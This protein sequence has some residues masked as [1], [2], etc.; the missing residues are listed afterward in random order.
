MSGY[1][2]SIIQQLL[3]ERPGDTTAE[4]EE[5][6]IQSPDGNNHQLRTAAVGLTHQVQ[7]VGLRPKRWT[8]GSDLKNFQFAGTL[9]HDLHNRRCQR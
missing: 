6:G 8:L 3:G 7:R 9:G 4:T 2:Q 1:P 5:P